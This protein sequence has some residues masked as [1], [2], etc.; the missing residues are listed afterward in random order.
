MVDFYQVLTSCIVCVLKSDASLL[1]HILSWGFA[2][3]LCGFLKNAL[4]N[5]RRGSL[6]SL[7]IYFSE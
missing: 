5:Q 2:H 4:D 3:S 6:Y 1:E 7:F